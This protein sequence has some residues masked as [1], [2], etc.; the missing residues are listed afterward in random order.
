MDKIYYNNNEYTKLYE[1][2]GG[3]IY[4]VSETSNIATS[5]L[6]VY[7]DET[8]KYLWNGITHPLGMLDGNQVVKN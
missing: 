5:W 7:P 4:F 3:G 2:E 8:V 1:H 6:D